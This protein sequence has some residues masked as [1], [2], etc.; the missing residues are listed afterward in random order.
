MKN[1]LFSKIDLIVYDFDGVLTNNHAYVDS[2][3]NEFVQVNR[4]DGLAISEFK[5][6]GFTQLIL[7]TEKNTVVTKRA[8]K[9]KIPCI[10]DSSDK[11][12]ALLSF[13]KTNHINIKKTIFIGNDINDLDVMGI[14]GLRLCPSDASEEIK[15]ISSLILKKKGG[16]GIVRELLDY[17]NKEVTT[18]NK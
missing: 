13:C 9:L 2:K 17:Y 1:S 11:K 15:S 8:E 6:F 7:S 4:S 14:V 5:K 10:Q 3:G 12:N 18:S 16:Q